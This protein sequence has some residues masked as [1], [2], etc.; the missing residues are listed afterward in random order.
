M[1]ERQEVS[2]RSH[3]LGLAS[4]IR[5]HGWVRLDDI[6][7]YARLGQPIIA[8]PAGLRYAQWPALREGEGGRSCVCSS[9]EG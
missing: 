5:G 4:Q 1:V 2:K 6:Q 9:Q 3:S 7:P 8:E